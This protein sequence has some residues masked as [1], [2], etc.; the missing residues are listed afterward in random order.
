MIELL[1]HAATISSVPKKP[2]HDQKQDQS[3]SNTEAAALSAG[4][5]R[6]IADRD[7]CRNSVH[8]M[9]REIIGLRA[10]ND[11]L[12][13]QNEQIGGIRDKYLRLATELLAQLK[14]IDYA[15]HEVVEKKINREG[16][17]EERDALASLAQRLSPSRATATQSTGSRQSA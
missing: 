16:E 7:R 11:E 13:R 6:L 17:A 10:V 9:E 2:D 8:D 4:I 3:D 1:K 15:I 12:L 5:Q 14:Q